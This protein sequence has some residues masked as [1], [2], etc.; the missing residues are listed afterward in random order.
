VSQKVIEP[1]T[2]ISEFGF[3]EDD[4]ANDKVE[5]LKETNNFT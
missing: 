5:E 4:E 1:K 2:E 3:D